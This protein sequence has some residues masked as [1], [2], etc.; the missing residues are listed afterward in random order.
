MKHMELKAENKKEEKEKERK[1]G[2]EGWW[3]EEKKQNK[4]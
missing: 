3:R 1:E 4:I 2:R